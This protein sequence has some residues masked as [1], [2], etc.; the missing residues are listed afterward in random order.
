M[1]DR[2]M[3]F[4]L[5]QETA[6]RIDRLAQRLAIPKSRVVREAVREYAVQAGRLS[7]AE[8]TRML[9]VFD[10]VIALIPERAAAEVDRE[11]DELRSARRSGGRASPECPE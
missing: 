4:S 8:R 2:K 5:D 11:L 7:E 1:N 10:E 6:E 9:G 3:T